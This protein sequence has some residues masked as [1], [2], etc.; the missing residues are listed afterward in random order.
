MSKI[1]ER[2]GRLVFDFNFQNQRCRELTKLEST[3]ANKKRAESILKKIDAEITLET[4]DY[5]KYFPKSKMAD[6]LEAKSLQ[7]AKKSSN[8]I[9]TFKE[10]SEQWIFEMSPSWRRTYVGTVNG[11]FYKYL[12][13]EFGDMHLDQIAKTDVLMYRNKLTQMPNKSG[14]PLAAA[15]IN[16]NITLMKSIMTEAA[17]RF[18]FKFNLTSVKP[19]K[20]VKPDIQ[21][22]SLSDI[23]KFLE[24]VRPDFK[25]YFITRFFT[26]MRSGEVNGLQWKHIDFENRQIIVEQALG[27][28]GVGDPKNEHA[29]REIHMCDLVYEALLNHKKTM[30]KFD[31]FVFCTSIDTPISNTNIHNRIWLPT[32]KLLGYSPRRLYQTRHTAASLWLASGES[33]EWI[34]RQLGHSTTEMLFRIYSRYVPNAL[35]TDGQ[36]FNKLIEANIKNSLG[37]GK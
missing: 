28:Y 12:I 37:E 4:F 1:T 22:L 30:K 29:F 2:N 5:K 26:G 16:K 3:P 32:L 35:R 18:N 27:V 8:E 25:D 17:E 21:P 7:L 36:A 9:P 24:I 6:K 13:P 11:N 23:T 33:P 34:A 14:V 19:L 20:G 31:D 15:T 10:F